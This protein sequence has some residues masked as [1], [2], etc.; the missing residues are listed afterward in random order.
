MTDQ[1]AKHI[2]KCKAPKKAATVKTIVE[3]IM[4]G[5]RRGYDTQLLAE[6]LNLKGIKTLVGKKWTYYSLQMQIR[7]MAMLD[8][9]SSLAWGL[10]M[11]IKEGKVSAND[12]ELLDARTR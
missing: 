12:L 6:K 10:S 2:E 3:W 11:L 1:Y 5:I 9:D 8:S 7:K 4:L